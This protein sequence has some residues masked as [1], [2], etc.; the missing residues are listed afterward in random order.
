MANTYTQI[1]IQNVFAIQNRQSL[2][3]NEWKDDLYK[4][5]TATIQHN[6]HKLLQIN[7]MPDHIHI[8]FGLRSIQSISD[9]MK[10]VIQDSSKW[11]NQNM[12]AK[13]K[14]SWQEGYGAF[15]YSKNQL[16]R[17]IKY[18]DSDPVA[19]SPESK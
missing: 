18:P 9:L 12:L 6:K 14:F 10:Q 8:L 3:G 5:I 13:G 19:K 15:S 7:G 17:T 4:Y 16:P 11:I 2:I 1:Q